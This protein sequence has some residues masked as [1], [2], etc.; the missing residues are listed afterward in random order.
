MSPRASAPFAVRN[1]AG[2][3][4]C[5]HAGEQNAAAAVNQFLTLKIFQPT[6]VVAP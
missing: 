3:R 6:V 2:Q 4:G 5:A 1:A